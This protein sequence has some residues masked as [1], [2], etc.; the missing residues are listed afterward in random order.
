MNDQWQE[1]GYAD[2][3]NRQ[4]AFGEGEIGRF[5]APLGLRPADVF[6]DFGCG[7]GEVLA[8]A[9]P[10][11]A[12][13]LGIDGSPRQVALARAAVAP[14]PHVEVRQAAF[15]DC[16]LAGPPVTRAV[17]RKSLHHL[18]DPDKAAFFAR[19][20]T[21]FAHGGLF[22]IE[23]GIFT[24]DRATLEEH[25]PQV[26]AD[27]EVWYGDRWPSIR[28]DVLATL[29]EEF[30]TGFTAWEAALRAGGFVVA[31]RFQRTCF[32]GGI[33]ARRER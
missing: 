26:L 6:V 4:Y 5:L 3:Y 16:D 21:A 9:A 12:R 22:L 25:L 10:R 11:V 2:R 29:R 24:F 15:L 13:A 32:Y 17:A 27:A 23:D 14:W 31:D 20:G 19:V 33:L 28:A 30:P 1:G 7:N 18:T 8:A